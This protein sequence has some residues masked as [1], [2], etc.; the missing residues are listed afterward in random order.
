[1]TVPPECCWACGLACSAAPLVQ[2][3]TG[4]MALQGLPL[5][6]SK[7]C[8]VRACHGRPLQVS[9]GMLTLRAICSC[10]SPGGEQQQG[11]QAKYWS[12]VL[13][14]SEGGASDMAGEYTQASVVI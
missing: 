5:Q 8:C 12:G 14:L 13:P 1:M 9:R 10:R 6:R 2:S 4:G 7:C 11:R 3:G